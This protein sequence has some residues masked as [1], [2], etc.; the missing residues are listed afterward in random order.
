MAASAVEAGGN[1]Q[2]TLVYIHTARETVPKPPPAGPAAAAAVIARLR[3]RRVTD[4]A[5]AGATDGT[6]CSRGQARI[7]LSAAKDG[8]K[9]CLPP[10]VGCDTV[11]V[12][13]AYM[14]G[15]YIGTSERSKTF[16]LS[17]RPHT[18]RARISLQL[19][20]GA[21]PGR[22][23]AARD[24]RRLSS[25]S[26]RQSHVTLAT[27]QARV[28]DV[29]GFTG[30]GQPPRVAPG[31]ACRDSELS[32]QFIKE[33]TESQYLHRYVYPLATH[34]IDIYTHTRW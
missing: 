30:A 23:T 29:P 24:Q 28:V 10:T 20:G 5:P 32:H 7:S 21:C 34:G 13:A 33:N 8:S 11:E 2:G 26:S 22:R 9:S 25:L 17:R 27:I 12:C 31:V 6:A 1:Q 18:V 14:H 16:R 4:T 3:V 15:I 19:A